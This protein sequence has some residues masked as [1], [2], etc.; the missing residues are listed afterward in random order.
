MVK[1]C[2]VQCSVIAPGDVIVGVNAQNNISTLF[3]LNAPEAA[4]VML[5]RSQCLTN[6]H[7][8][9]P[10][11]SGAEIHLKAHCNNTRGRGPFSAF[12]IH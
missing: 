2:A 11:F 1:V 10:S 7:H 6:L 4:M 8:L 3:S 5:W 12:V 9:L